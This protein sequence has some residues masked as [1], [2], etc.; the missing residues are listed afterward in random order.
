[1]K[2]FQVTFKDTIEAE[3]EEEAYAHIRQYC[4]SVACFGDVTAFDFINIEGED[5]EK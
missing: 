1:M 5:D 2:K 4:V 3:T